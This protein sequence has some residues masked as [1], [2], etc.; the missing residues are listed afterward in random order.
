M[1]RSR[2]GSATRQR[3]VDLD[4]KA[5]KLR[6]IVAGLRG[7]MADSDSPQ[8]RK[9][10]RRQP[11]VPRT[12]DALDIA[13]DRVDDDD[14]A[15]AL[16]AKHTELLKAQIASERLDHGAKRMSIAARFLLAFAALAVAAG[17][18]LM[19]RAARADR[20]LVVEAFSTPPDLAARGL[21][22]VVL[23]AGVADRLGEIDRAAN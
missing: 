3:R 6:T 18:I 2:A 8:P 1:A 22:G 17:L 12:P 10:P 5:A 23:A 20:G 19:V 11:L 14:A 15:R 16:L 7:R 9:R 13:L 4:R 21:T